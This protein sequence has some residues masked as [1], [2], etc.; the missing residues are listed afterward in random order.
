M[1]LAQCLLGC[2]ERGGLVG[3][4]DDGGVAV[5]LQEAGLIQFGVAVGLGGPLLVTYQPANPAADFWGV[6]VGDDA[7]ITKGWF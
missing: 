3:S 4:G 6:F 7:C 2:Y 5:W 1:V